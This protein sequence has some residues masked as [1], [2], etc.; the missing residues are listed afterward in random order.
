MAGAL[1]I[2]AGKFGDVFGRRRMLL[3]G[4]VLFASFSVVGAL[5]PNLGVL[6]AGRALRGVGAAL[7]L[8]ATLALI[9]PQFSGR[10]LLTAFGVWQ[11]VAWAG[12]VAPAIG[13]ILTD[14][15]GWA[16]LFWINVPL[17]IAAFAV[18]RASTLESADPA[19]SRRVDWAGLATIGLAVFTLLYALTDGPSVGWPSPLVLGLFAASVCWPSLGC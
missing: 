2:A 19:A 7:I 12:Q 10:A 14:T 16:W 5:A 8:P 3:L 11:A 1:V 6:I 18:I 13:G 9:P 17:G 4:V 15:I